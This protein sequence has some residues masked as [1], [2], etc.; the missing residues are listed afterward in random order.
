M[1]QRSSNTCPVCGTA[2]ADGVCS[3]CGYLRIVFPGTL[4]ESVKAQESARI[5]AAKQTFS[6]LS[7]TIET[8]KVALGKVSKEKEE[9]ESRIRNLTD[10]SNRINAQLRDSGAQLRDITARLKDTESKLKRAKSEIDGLTDVVA[11]KNAE[12]A[13]L[14]KE[15][16]DL[17]KRPVVTK[18]FLILKDDGELSVL[19]VMNERKYYATGPGLSLCPVPESQIHVLPVMTSTRVAFSI[20]KND[21]G[22]YRLTDLAGTLRSSGAKNGNKFRLTQGVT[23]RID[24]CDMELHFSVSQS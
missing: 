4:P 7:Q 10:D 21:S 16:S 24:G 22:A 1:N 3:K 12:I 9:L 18:A 20:E 13:R 6:E 17:A 11:S 14:E 19:P 5:A 23:V 15:K 2:L 8:N